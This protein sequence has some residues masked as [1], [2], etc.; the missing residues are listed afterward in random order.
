MIKLAFAL[1]ATVTWFGVWYMRKSKGRQRMREIDE[2]KRCV[3]CDGTNLQSHR[4]MAR[5]LKCG[6]TVSLAA[7]KSAMVNEDELDNITKP[8]DRRGL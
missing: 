8:D 3:A 7:F 5:C 6:H 1:I 4:G 2:G